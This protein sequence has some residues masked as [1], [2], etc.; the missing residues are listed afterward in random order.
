MLFLASSWVR[1][2]WTQSSDIGDKLDDIALTINDEDL[3]D[4]RTSLGAVGTRRI[5]RDSLS[6]LFEGADLRH[7][8]N[9]DEPAVVT[10]KD[11]KDYYVTKL[12]NG[13]YEIE[14]TSQSD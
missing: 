3:S 12:D 6:Y 7:L 11:G 10:G 8:L 2:N 1:S 5:V 9:H 14:L 4:A 13:M